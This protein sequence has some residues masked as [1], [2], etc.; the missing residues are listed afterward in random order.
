MMSR[1]KL[2]LILLGLS[3][4]IVPSIAYFLIQMEYCIN[5]DRIFEISQVS[6]EIVD[7]EYKIDLSIKNIGKET[8]KSTEIQVLTGG[9]YTPYPDW[10]SKFSSLKPGETGNIEIKRPVFTG[11]V[12]ADA[13][14]VEVVCAITEKSHIT[15]NTY[16]GELNCRSF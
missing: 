16:R 5:K 6:C 12:N 2:I 7:N 8:I 4:I 11:K 15:I 13:F 14:E 1:W 9:H 10:T 3:I